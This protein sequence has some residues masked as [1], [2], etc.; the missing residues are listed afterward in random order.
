MTFLR[1][2]RAL[3][4][5]RGVL[6]ILDEIQTGIGRTGSLFGF[7]HAGIDA[8]HHDARARGWAEACRWPPWW[9]IATC[10]ASSMAIRAARSAAT[11]SWRRS[12][13]R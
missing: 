9:R 2:L 5:E 10:A 6:L 13:A 4:R 3:T 11:R 8:G 12:A 1:G 7:E